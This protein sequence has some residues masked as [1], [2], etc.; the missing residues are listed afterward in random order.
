MF[1]AVSV[2][3]GSGLC[4]VG[5]DCLGLGAMSSVTGGV[6]DVRLR[7][8]WFGSG[9]CCL[10]ALR[11]GGGFLSGD[12]DSITFSRWL[13]LWRVNNGQLAGKS[14]IANLSA[15]RSTLNCG[16]KT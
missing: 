12:D 7:S 1:S 5:L 6:V 16:L 14:W 8:W 4:G 9:K 3:V 13:V 10:Q 15:L 2:V 11:F